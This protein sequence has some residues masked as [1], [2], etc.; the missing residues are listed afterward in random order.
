[1]KKESKS[2][3]FNSGATN[4]H[5]VIQNLSEKSRKNVETRFIVSIV[6]VL[7]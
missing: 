4:N 7:S 5:L 3:N 2:P 1:M 6:M